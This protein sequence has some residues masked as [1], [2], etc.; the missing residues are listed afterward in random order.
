MK[1]KRNILIIAIIAIVA[2][3]SSTMA[4]LCGLD[5]HHQG[6]VRRRAGH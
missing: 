5:H 1:K 4:A 2:A 6:R 3:I